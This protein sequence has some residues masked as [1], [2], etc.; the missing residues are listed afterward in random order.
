M[1]LV[2]IFETQIIFKTVLGARKPKDLNRVAMV[3]YA[4]RRLYL[5]SINWI[6]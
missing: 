6:M 4:R 1:C 2:K 3:T 5:V